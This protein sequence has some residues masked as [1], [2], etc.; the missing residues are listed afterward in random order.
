MCRAVDQCG[1]SVDRVLTFPDVVDPLTVFDRFY[2]SLTLESPRTQGGL[3][4]DAHEQ[5]FVDWDLRT[6]R[7]HS[8]TETRGTPFY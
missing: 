3:K 1:W 2:K 7:S 6:V 8:G 5:N 4:V